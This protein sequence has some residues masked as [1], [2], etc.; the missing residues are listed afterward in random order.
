MKLVIIS[1]IKKLLP[2]E[3]Q[4]VSAAMARAA[5]GSATRAA[6]ASRRRALQQCGL[7]LEHALWLLWA[8]AR[9]ALRA[10]CGPPTDPKMQS[11]YHLG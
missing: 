5:A 4:Q 7:A 1:D 3:S 2:P 11:M 6:L 8:H 9:V 10:A